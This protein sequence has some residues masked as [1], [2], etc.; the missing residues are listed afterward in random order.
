M[1][2]INNSLFINKLKAICI[3]LMVIG[4]C[5]GP[6]QFC[7]WFYL[8][9][10]PCFFFIS[11]Y[12]FNEKYIFLPVTFIWKKIKSLYMPY[13]KYGVIFLI[14]HYSFPFLYS[15]PVEPLKNL[16][17]LFTFR[18]ADQLLGGYWF[19]QS[20]FFSMMMF[21]FT[22]YFMYKKIEKYKC[23]LFF[24]PCIFCLLSF[25]VSF[26]NK[27]IPILS[28]TN[29][30]A[31]SYLFVGYLAK[32]YGNRINKLFSIKLTL[33]SLILTIA[34]V[35]SNYFEVVNMA[36]IRRWNILVY[37]VASLLGILVVMNLTAVIPPIFDKC[38][39]YLGSR[40]LAVLTWHM[41]GFK[42]V[43]AAIIIL[44]GMPMSDISSYPVLHQSSNYRWILYSIV[45]VMFSL[46]MNY[47]IASINKKCKI[48]L[49]A[50]EK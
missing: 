33:I 47:F 32:K 38:L 48:W 49:S 36:L 41:L 34:L 29:F 50:K 46:M 21:Y 18:G 6:S 2:Q 12:L 30:L 24:F 23:L 40:T 31:T 45:G 9:H 42:I 8:F 39:D 27:N 17:L 35:V 43:S 25:G 7:H 37:Y 44:K 11:G 20:L 1:Y 4:H 16:L 3:L 10:M 5:G 26:F 14:I 22:L 15:T 28:S 13:L 19:L